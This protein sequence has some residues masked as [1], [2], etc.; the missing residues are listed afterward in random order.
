MTCEM[1]RRGIVG[2][3]EDPAQDV[4]DE[5]RDEVHI[6]TPRIEEHQ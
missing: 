3:E 6:L 1:T 4:V 2:E 5:V